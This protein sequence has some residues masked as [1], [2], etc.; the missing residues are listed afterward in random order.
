MTD[1]I[2]I[3]MRPPELDEPTRRLLWI[4]PL[5]IAIWAILLSIFS[6]IL[7]RTTVPHEELKPIDARLIEIPPPAGLQGGGATHPSVPAIPHPKSA[8]IVKPHPATHVTKTAPVPPVIRSPYGIGKSTEAPTAEAPSSAEGT[9]PNTGESS[10]PSGGSVGGIG[11]DTIGARAIY[12]PTPVIPDDLRQDVIETEAV[13]HFKVSFDGIA[14][15]TLEKPTSSPHLN[16]VL[17]DTLKQW[18]FFP[19]M[20]NGVAI[21][22]SF[23]VRIPV[24]V[25]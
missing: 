22:S 5:A 8:P 3:V 24:S 7:M 12:A 6:L 14:E 19:A 9:A 25:Q 16:Q 23:E 21:E 11:S 1:A 2:R 18:K 20:K 17:L 15:V 13:A 10:E 4:I